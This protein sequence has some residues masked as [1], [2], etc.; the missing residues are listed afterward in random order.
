MDFYGHFW[1]DSWICTVVYQ[2]LNLTGAVNMCGTD[3]VLE[4]TLHKKLT[5]KFDT[6][7]RCKKTTTSGF[8]FFVKTSLTFC[9]RMEKTLVRFLHKP[10][11]TSRFFHRFLISMYCN[12]TNRHGCNCLVL[13]T[14]ALFTGS[15]VFGSQAIRPLPPFSSH[16]LLGTR[17]SPKVLTVG[18]CTESFSHK[19]NKKISSFKF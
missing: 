12:Y 5:E 19:K 15:G 16:C 14:F 18:M 4:N 2:L 9:K 13:V 7:N 1:A 11:N 17:H 3:Q 10:F 6:L 8:L